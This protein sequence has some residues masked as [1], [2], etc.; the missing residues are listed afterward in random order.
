MNSY[1]FTFSFVCIKKIT[2]EADCHNRNMHPVVDLVV[3]LPGE[4]FVVHQL[5][6]NPDN[7]VVR[8]V[9]TVPEVALLH[10]R[11]AADDNHVVDNHCP[12]VVVHSPEVVLHRVA[13]PRGVVDID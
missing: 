13:A 3:V 10:S 2:E 4:A 11:P 12:V 5:D 7:L 8:V 6:D 9:D 1:F